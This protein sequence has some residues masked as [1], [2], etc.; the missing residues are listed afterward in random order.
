MTF[1]PRSFEE[2]LLDMITHVRANTTLTDFSVGSVIRTLLEAAALE[3]DEQYFQMVQLLDAFR[4]ATATGSD[5]DERAADMD[6]VRLPAKE[7]FGTIVVRNGNLIKDILAFDI[8]SGVSS[9]T[10][11]DTSNFPLTPPNFNCRIGEG[12]P[13][14]EDVEVSNNI[15]ISNTL[16]LV[17]PTTQNHVS[18][19]RVSVIS[20]SDISIASGEQVQVPP[21]SFNLA[22]KFTFLETGMIIAGDY[23]SN[24]INIISNETGK[25]GNV[26]AGRISQFVSASPFAGATVTNISDTSGGRDIE[27][28]DEFRSR[29][30][31]KFSKLSRGVS[32]AIEQTVVGVEDTNTAKQITTAK[33]QE[34]F[35]SNEHT[36]YIDDGT[37]LI[38]DYVI[39]GTT[40]LSSGATGGSTQILSVVDAQNFPSSGLLLVGADQSSVAEICSFLSKGPGNKLNLD[41]AVV[42]THIAGEE[43]L[44]VADLGTAEEGQNF[45]KLPYYPIR[46]NNYEIYDNSTG[47]IEKR[48]E[49]EYFLNR[50]NGEIEYVGSGL[51]S[52]TKVYA[53]FSY[54]TGIM[55]LAQK[56]LNGD[57]KNKVDFPGVVAAGIIINVDVPILRRITVLLSISVDNGYDTNAVGQD[58]IRLVTAYVDGLTIGDNVIVAKIIERAM[59]VEGVE[60]V[61]VRYPI[62]DI[63]VLENE[64]PVTFDSNGNSLV[65]VYY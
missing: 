25:Q 16:T 63:V 5:L 51:S 30:M 27:T 22:I 60:N 65:A 12:T 7:A 13:Q 37:G 42:N 36:L 59:S 32:E 33:L 17:N 46:K 40:T 31:V 4:I 28:D 8:A 3:D 6:E 62:E 1:I 58:V 57:P 45:F 49:D 50:T 47:L 19:E 10:L 44:L 9:I 38:P 53:N 61:V 54:Y 20:G 41:A 35:V 11:D 2:I 43:V 34:D 56:V 24:A 26:S 23:E 18:G 52:G 15:I 14:V 64:L 21:S 39:M 48:S 55:Q 29:L